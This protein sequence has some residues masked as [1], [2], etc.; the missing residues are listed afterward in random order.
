MSAAGSNRVKVVQRKFIG[1]AA[2]R[3]AWS[4]STT[5]G[6]A[7]NAA[8]PASLSRQPPPAANLLGRILRKPVVMKLVMPADL[9]SGN[10]FMA[11]GV[12]TSPLN[13]ELR[14][15]RGHETK[16]GELNP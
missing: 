11:V 14:Y 3:A 6:H 9:A 13:F 1:L 10:D 15:L 8:C 2:A 7:R 5:S 16:P 4:V 12:K